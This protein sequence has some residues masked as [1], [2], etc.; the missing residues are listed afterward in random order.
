MP[1]YGGQESNLIKRQKNLP[2]NL[3]GVGFNATQRLASM[4]LSWLDNCL[5]IRSGEFGDIGTFEKL[6]L[7]IRKLEL[8]LRLPF[9]NQI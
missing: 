8:I 9:Q 6:K 3:D 1:A 2:Q 4:A 7:N 5:D